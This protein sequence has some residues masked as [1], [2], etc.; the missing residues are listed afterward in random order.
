MPSG[1][2]GIQTSRQQLG[3]LQREKTKPER[4]SETQSRRKAVEGPNMLGIL[5]NSINDQIM[6]SG[7]ENKEYDHPSIVYKSVLKKQKVSSALLGWTHK[8]VTHTPDLLSST[9]TGHTVSQ[10]GY[11]SS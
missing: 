5:Y 11:N 4:I 1:G 10:H 8:L 2:A 9:Y 6:F 3:R 7:E